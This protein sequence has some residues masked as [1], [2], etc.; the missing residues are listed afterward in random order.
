MAGAA[1]ASGGGGGG[2]E[3]AEGVGEW[4]VGLVGFAASACGDLYKFDLD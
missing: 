3:E 2:E 4:F 1:P